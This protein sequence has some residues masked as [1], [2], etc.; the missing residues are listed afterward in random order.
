[1]FLVKWVLP[2]VLLSSNRNLNQAVVVNKT[3][4]S[5]EVLFKPQ[6]NGYSNLP[7]PKSLEFPESMHPRLS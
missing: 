2:A 7:T 1:M 5:K 3:L 6:V 4:L